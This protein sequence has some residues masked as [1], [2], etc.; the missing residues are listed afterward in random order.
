MIPFDVRVFARI[1]YRSFFASGD[2]DAPLTF[3]RACLL[4]AGLTGFLL[5]QLFNVICLLMD[6]ILFNGY[7]RVRHPWLAMV[8]TYSPLSHPADNLHRYY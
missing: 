8:T 2:T 6:E 7:R 3:R 4:L 1:V 5:L